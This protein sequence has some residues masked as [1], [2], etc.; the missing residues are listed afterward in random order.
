MHSFAVNGR[1]LTRHMT[2]VDRYAHELMRNI[3]SL[4]D[5]ED[6]IVVVPEDA[7]IISN[8]ELSKMRIVEY[9]HRSGYAWEQLDFSHYA[10]H[11]GRV[12][13]NLC[14]TAPLRNPGIVCV[15]DMATLAH[16]DFFSWKFTMAY[17]VMFG[18][19]TTRADKL[20]TVSDFSRR[21]IEKYYPAS[22]GK[23]NVIGNAW[24]HMLRVKPDDSVLAKHGLLEKGFWFA[25][26]S[27]APNKNLK[28]I[29]ETALLNPG[30]TFVVAGGVNEKVFGKH[31]IPRADNVKY[32][33]Y[34]S[35]PEAKALLE[36]CRGFLYPTF[37]EGFGIPPMEALSCGA[38]AFVSDTEIMHE[39]YGDSVIYIDPGIPCSDLD[40]FPRPA[41]DREEILDKYTWRDSAA[42][43]L[44]LLKEFNA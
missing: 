29:V 39:I 36:A 44:E 32:V 13:I 6:I 8:L 17:R 35:D 34:V 16:G 22:K 1:F 21:E 27:L 38:E 26:S 28:W 15:H 12:A 30:A 42:K 40:S 18:V 11:E 5:A 3:D 4:L 7:P 23:I 9:G 2:G 25:M 19:I 41:G 14:N 10:R 43:L 31:D 37:Y 24:D 33:G 20:I